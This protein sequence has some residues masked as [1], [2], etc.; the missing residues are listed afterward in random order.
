MSLWPF[1]ETTT[2]KNPTSWNSQSP[3]G[4]REMVAELRQS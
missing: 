4:L 1:R 3:Q 2:R